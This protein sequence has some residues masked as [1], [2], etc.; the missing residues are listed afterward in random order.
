M[1]PVQDGWNPSRILFG[2]I[3]LKMF[4]RLSEEQILRKAMAPVSPTTTTATSMSDLLL[5]QDG[6]FGI[7]A[8]LRDP[9]YPFL[10]NEKQKTNKQNH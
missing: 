4:K 7:D 2:E 6:L 1:K 5:S 10:N 3:S 8:Q 9:L